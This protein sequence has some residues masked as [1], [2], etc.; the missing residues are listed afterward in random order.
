M[1]KIIATHLREG[2]KGKFVSLE[3]MGD[4]ELVQSMNTGKFYATAKKCFVSSTFT[5][6]HARSLVGSTIPGSIIRVEADPYEFTVPETGEVIELS[7]TYSYLP[8]NAPN[9]IVAETVE[10]LA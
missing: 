8:P 4:V 5:E 10:I 7:H 6:E 9:P 3:L 1:V 2:E